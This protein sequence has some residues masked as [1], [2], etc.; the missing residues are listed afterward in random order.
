MRVEYRLTD[1]GHQ[2]AV[3]I[4]ELTDWI[5]DHIGEVLLARQQHD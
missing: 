2:V 1:S 5:E 3:R 4:A